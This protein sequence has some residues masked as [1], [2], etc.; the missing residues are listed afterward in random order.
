LRREPQILLNTIGSGSAEPGLCCGNRR[1][2][3]LAET[4]V[5]PRLAIGDV[6]PGQAS[7]SLSLVLPREN[8]TQLCG[9]FG[10]PAAAAGDILAE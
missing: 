6:A 5:K 8:R 4:H 3:G 10:R 7:A 1:R 9:T 2:V